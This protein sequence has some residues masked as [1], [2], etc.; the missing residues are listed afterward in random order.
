MGMAHGAS[1]V[2]CKF[3]VGDAPGSYSCRLIEE[4]PELGEHVAI[5]GGC[6]STLF[7]TVREQARKNLGVRKRPHLPFIT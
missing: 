4:N 1:E 3:L 7:N 6:S 5:G 2:G